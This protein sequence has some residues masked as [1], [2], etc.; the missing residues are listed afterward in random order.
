M[1][2]HLFKNFTLSIVLLFIGNLASAEA[3]LSEKVFYNQGDEFVLKVYEE[4]PSVYAHIDSAHDHAYVDKYYLVSF[5]GICKRSF[6]SYS[7]DKS[8]ALQQVLIS[9]E[10]LVKS[11]VKKWVN[12]EISLKCEIRNLIESDDYREGVVHGG[13][14]ILISP[15]PIELSMNK[16]KFLF[17]LVYN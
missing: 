2:S 10:A 14:G 12:S 5:H 16:S 17:K 13:A 9:H 7:T 3:T 15:L 6:Q 4:H 11:V 1:A 8:Y